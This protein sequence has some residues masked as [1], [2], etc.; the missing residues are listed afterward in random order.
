MKKKMLYIAGGLAG[1]VVILVITAYLLLDANSFRPTIEAQLSNAL[2]RKVQVGDLKLSLFAGG[3]SA[4]DISIADDPAF[5]HTPFLSAKSVDV[6][7]EMMP[8]LFSR[9]V[10][11][12][13]LTQKE[14]ELGGGPKTAMA[15]APKELAIQKLRIVNGR[16]M[17]GSWL[18]R[19]KP[20]AY[21]AV[22]VTASNVSYE[23][24][25][26]F[27]FAAK[28]PGGGDVKAEGMVGPI[29]R[30]DAAES[31]SFEAERIVAADVGH[32]RPSASAWGSTASRRRAAGRHH[33]Y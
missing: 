7:V 2:D 4:R 27:T 18:T 33:R 13:A 23:S 3:I 15:S 17:V 24:Q 5:S 14:P 21:E 30:E 19:D 10:R 20:R 28:T 16:V 26:P 11:V 22:N 12:T 32:S 9:S 31:P 8:L 29:N 25:I 1:V 6:S